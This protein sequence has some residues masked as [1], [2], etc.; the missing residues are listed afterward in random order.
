MDAPLD[1][2]ST[3][4]ADERELLEAAHSD[5]YWDRVVSRRPLNSQIAPP[6]QCLGREIMRDS[7][8]RA[9]AGNSVIPGNELLELIGTLK[10]SGM[11]ILPTRIQ[12]SAPRHRRHVALSAEQPRKTSLLPDGPVMDRLHRL[13]SHLFLPRRLLL[14]LRFTALTAH[15][16]AMPVG[17]IRHL[18]PQILYTYYY[19]PRAIMLTTT[20]T[21]LVLPIMMRYFPRDLAACRWIR[22]VV[23][24]WVRPQARAGTFLARSVHRR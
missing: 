21:T 16:R 24:S 2:V 7:L 6:H 23:E 12:V 3:S 18:R 22:V 17:I 15:R 4:D 8:V 9:I 14:P 20:I 10:M 19:L 13:P 5:L 11:P 1:E